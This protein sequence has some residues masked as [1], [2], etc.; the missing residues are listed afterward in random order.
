MTK[1]QLKF[2]GSQSALSVRYRKPGGCGSA[3]N[4]QTALPAAGFQII[5]DSFSTRMLLRLPFVT[6]DVSCL[7]AKNHASLRLRTCCVEPRPRQCPL[8][9]I[10]GERQ[11]RLCQRHYF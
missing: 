4:G 1:P 7:I 6:D 9:D 3:S 2:V 5:I 10:Q 11:W 8:G